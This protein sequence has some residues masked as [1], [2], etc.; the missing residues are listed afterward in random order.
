MPTQAARRELAAAGFHRL[1]VVGRG[2]DAERFAPARRSDGAARAR[3]RPADDA[4]VLLASAA[5]PPRR[6]SSSRLRA[7]EAVRRRAARARMVVVG[8]GPARGRAASAR[9]RR[10][11]FV[12]AQRGDA[13][14]AHYASADAVPLP[15]PLRHLRQRRRSRRS[16]PACRS[17]RSTAPPPPSTSST[18]VSGRLVAPGDEAGFIAAAA[19]LAVEPGASAEPMRDAAVAAARRGHWDEVLERFE[20]RLQ[21]TVDAYQA[22]PAAVPVVA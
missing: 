14:A 15:E 21:D 6:T 8:D 5:S 20:A 19:A 2:V 12:G 4:P 7:F 1:A 13:L 22:P 17:S 10:V 16:P 9:I 11:R 3:G 18:A